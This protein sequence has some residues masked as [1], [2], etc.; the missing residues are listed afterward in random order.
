MIVQATTK[1]RQ[2]ANDMKKKNENL[3]DR[4]KETFYLFNSV[5]NN[6]TE[7]QRSMLVHF[8]HTKTLLK[9]NLPT[10]FMLILICSAEAKFVTC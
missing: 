3:R 5:N 2:K 4:E 8:L 9:N 7:N 1:Q 10:T 6:M